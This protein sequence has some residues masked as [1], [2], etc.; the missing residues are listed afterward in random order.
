MTLEKRHSGGVR[1]TR[2]QSQ[3]PPYP[4]SA[5]STDY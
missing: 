1:C 3:S 4:H 2:Q 5:K